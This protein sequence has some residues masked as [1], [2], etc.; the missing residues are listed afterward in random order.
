[1]SSA[2]PTITSLTPFV[3]EHSAGDH[4]V[5]AA[6]LKQTPAL[7]LADGTVL[8]VQAEGAA[9]RVEAHPGAG[10]LTAASDGAA[11][12]TGGD[13]GRVVRTTPDG[14]TELVGDEKG[15]WIDALALSPSGAMAWSANKT[16]TARDDKGR[17]KTWTAPS[18][19]QGLCFAPKGYRLAV[20]HY[21]GV[22]LW[23]PNTEAAPE[24]LEW[25]GSHLD[26]TWSADGRFVV[27]SMQENSLHGWR[28]PEKADMRMS[29]Y[30]S[31][32]RSFSWSHDGAWLATSGADAAIVWPFS[33]KEGPMGK[34]PRECGV[35]PAKVSRV[36]F[37]PSALVLAIG[38]E[39]GFI[40][41]VR[42]NDAAEIL[43]RKGDPDHGAITALA[44]DKR[45]AHL[46]FGTDGG[47]AGV[48][49]LPA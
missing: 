11:L 42:L 28:L 13:D 46:L 31:K 27:S 1:M 12:V 18:T 23:F 49:T 48:L 8:L 25:K 6:F 14:G 22:S 10:I 9:R 2:P 21:N 35:R 44:W 3:V 47:A 32:T 30:P 41:L 40:L 29:G 45:G 20:S 17:L 4:V 26:V 33:S 38:Y 15:R 34:P 43:V 16:V 5:G 7:A 36:A 24:R 39:D 37:H 19:P